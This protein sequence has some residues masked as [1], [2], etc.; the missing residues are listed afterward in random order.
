MNKSGIIIISQQKRRSHVRKR[1]VTS[2]DDK[3]RSDLSKKEKKLKD[4]SIYN[5]V[6]NDAAF[7]AADSVF[8]FLSFGSEIDTKKIIQHALDHNKKVFLPKVIGKKL[9]LF[10]MKDF[11]NLEKSKFGILEPNAY[12]E[13]IGNC[14]IDFILVPGLAFDLSGGRVG[15]GGGYYDRYISSLPKYETIPKVA[16][17]YDF[18]IVDEVP[19][20]KYDIP[21]DRI[22]IDEVR[23][24]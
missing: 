18:Q 19:M 5:Q 12:C 11:E 2:T 8:L 16:I 23:V 4:E 3:K 22:I 21:V 17:A 24:V 13:S 15:Y 1:S 20:N 9:E 14:G 10:K 6:V 7:I